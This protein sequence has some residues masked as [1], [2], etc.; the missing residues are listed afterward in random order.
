MDTKKTSAIL[1]HC[2]RVQDQIYARVKHIL[3]SREK[4]FKPKEVY[5]KIQVQSM[6]NKVVLVWHP[7]P[8]IFCHQL[9]KMPLLVWE[10]NLQAGFKF[11]LNLELEIRSMLGF[12]N[13]LNLEPN[14]NPTLRWIW[15]WVYIRVQDQRYSRFKQI[16]LLVKRKK[17]YPKK[18]TLRSKSKAWNLKWH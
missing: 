2:A 9:K 7:Y 17:S 4:K 13:V 10:T 18:F 6:K 14:A 3:V 5:T 16:I 1:V 11:E 12:S 8:A 15:G